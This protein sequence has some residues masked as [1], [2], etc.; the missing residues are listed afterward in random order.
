MPAPVIAKRDALNLVSLACIQV[1]NS[2]L[3]LLVFPLVL[4][5]VGANLY[6]KVALAEAIALLVVPFVLY[7]FEVDGVARIVGLDPVADIDRVSRVFSAVLYVRLAIFVLCLGGTLLLSPWLDHDVFRLLLWWMLIPLSHIAQS[8]WLFQGL[9]RNAPV[10]AFTL[11][12]RLL[13]VGVI[14][15]AI[16]SPGDVDLVPAIIGVLYLAGALAS[17]TYAFAV[18][19]IRLRRVPLAELRKQVYSGKE[20]FFGNASVILYRDM[21][22]LMLGV[23]GAGDKAIAAYSIAEKLVKSL[24]ASMR[25]LNQLFFPKALRSLRAHSAA[26]LAA[27]KTMLRMTL[28]QW[29]ALALLLATLLAAYHL[30]LD[31]VPSVRDFP[32]RAHVAALVAV[33]AASVFFGIANFM[34]GTAGLNYLQEKAYYFKAILAVGIVNVMLCLALSARF[35]GAGASAAFVVAETLL[36]VLV[37]GRYVRSGKVADVRPLG[38]RS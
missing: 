16:R 1:S 30:M 12:S 3:P 26:D 32:N 19:G 17:L 4:K 6:A 5:V 37:A 24:Q 33:M 28:P 29:G 22:V 7:S 31:R 35:G 27:L 2:V 14:I 13:C 15:A 18:L 36:F 8:F 25:P 10:A 34:L 23:V 38:E 21:N 11:V 9:E 20:I